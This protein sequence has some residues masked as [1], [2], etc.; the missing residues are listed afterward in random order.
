MFRSSTKWF[1][2]VSLSVLI[3]SCG[4]QEQPKTQTAQEDAPAPQENVPATTDTTDSKVPKPEDVTFNMEAM[5]EGPDIYTVDTA[6]TDMH[7]TIVSNSAGP[8][9]G[10]FPTG[11]SGWLNLAEGKGKFA[12]KIDT[13][14]TTTADGMGLE[15]RDHNII[16]AFFGVRPSVAMPEAVDK[17]WEALTGKIERN[18]PL[19]GFEIEKIDGL[20]DVADGASGQ[21]SLSGTLVFWDTITASVSFPVEAKR[22]GDIL[23][24]SST[25]QVT[26]NL[27]DIMGQSLRDLAF[28]TMI[29]AG[30]AHQPGIQND[31]VIGLDKVVLQ[32]AGN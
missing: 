23:T 10:R 5:P 6:E 31:V 8:V 15:R 17:A 4:Q 22:E 12:A 19:A 20:T 24:L 7:F 2:L 21:G 1:M 14:T 9:T 11:Y 32:K 18:I 29:A 26:V 13:L 27:V 16:E 28:H 30:C 3:L 25:E